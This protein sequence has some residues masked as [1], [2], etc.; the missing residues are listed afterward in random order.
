MTTHGD[1]MLDSVRTA[2]GAISQVSFSCKSSQITITLTNGEVSIQKD[3]V[4][5]MGNASLRGANSGAPA[6]SRSSIGVRFDDTTG[7]AAKLAIIVTEELRQV[8]GTITWNSGNSDVTVAS[9]G[10]TKTVSYDSNGKS[11]SI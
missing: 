5:T 7:Q 9:N 11:F 4:Y 3:A 8:S 1:A 10:T 6:L 2:T